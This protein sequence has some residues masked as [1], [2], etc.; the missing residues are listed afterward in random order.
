MAFYV[1]LLASGRQGTFYVGVTNDL[2]RRVHEHKEKTGSVFTRRYGVDQLVYYETYDRPDEAIRREKRL[3][4]WPRDWK[5]R[6][7]EAFNPGWRDLYEDL[8]L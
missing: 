4:R 2:A 8:N 6:T 3:K 5:V 7:I 1:Y